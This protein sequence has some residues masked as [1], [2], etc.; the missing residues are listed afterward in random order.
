M[1]SKKERWNM[2]IKRIKKEAIE[3][4]KGPRTTVIQKSKLFQKN[5]FKEKKE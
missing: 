1:G 5:D 2:K 3:T 4:R